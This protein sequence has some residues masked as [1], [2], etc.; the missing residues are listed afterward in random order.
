M[1]HKV[2]IIDMGTNTFHLLLAQRDDKGYE[3][4][5][6]DRAAVKIGKGGINKGHITD[7]GIA[8]AVVAMQGFKSI[9]DANKVESIKAVG[10]SALRSASNC[11]DVLSAI[12]AVTGIHVSVISGE[13]EAEYIYLG[14]REAIKM[15][16]EKNLVIDIG[17]GS[18]ELIIANQHQIFW[19]KS[20]EIGAQR[21]LEKFHKHDPITSEE[22]EMLNSY[23]AQQLLP[24]FEALK[25]HSPGI[26]VGAS[27][28]FDT[29]SDIYCAKES[30]VKGE[31][32][33]ETPLT[34]DA[35]YQIFSDIVS[36][37]RTER[38]HIQGMIEMRVD[39][40]VVACCLIKYILSQHVFD[41]IRVS[42]YS[43]KE[44]VLA[45]LVHSMN[46]AQF[47]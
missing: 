32:D 16:L 25:I 1:N 42:S 30:I 9:I 40:I 8:R 26:L 46:T 39:M 12:H 15:G 43:L 35:F 17:G 41:R 19:K 47:T 2:A 38:M 4:V 36:K 3:I 14:V 10:T 31:Y 34:I 22:I 23:F 28:T 11:A 6:R 44:G 29:L 21:L 24:L 20:L 5:F 37:N 27:G 18:V 45:S 7:D 33:P 13:M